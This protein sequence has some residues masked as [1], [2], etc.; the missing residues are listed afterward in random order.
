MYLNCP[1]CGLWVR[2]QAMDLVMEHCPRCLARTRRVSHMQLS[3]SPHMLSSPM[4]LGQPPAPRAPAEEA[5]AEAEQVE[6]TQSDG[7]LESEAEV[8]GGGGRDEATEE[9]AGL[10]S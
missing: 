1:S 2:V 4:T 5:R 10:R 7:E 3:D 6:T 8:A 9:G